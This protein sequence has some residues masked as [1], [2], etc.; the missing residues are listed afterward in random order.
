MF[1]QSTAGWSSFRGRAVRLAQQ[2]RGRADLTRHRPNGRKDRKRRAAST[3]TPK[4]PLINAARQRL[5]QGKFHVPSSDEISAVVHTA[6]QLAKWGIPW[7]PSRGWRRRLEAKGK[8]GD[9][10]R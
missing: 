9:S 3:T 7:P 10:C 4:H 1:V 2:Q 8:G 5:A 6:M